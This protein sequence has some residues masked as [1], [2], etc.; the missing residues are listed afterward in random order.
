ML[1]SCHSKQQILQN[2]TFCRLSS[3]NITTHSTGILPSPGVKTFYF[4]VQ[5]HV[6]V[7]KRC[8]ALPG[9]IHRDLFRP[10][11]GMK[12]PS[13]NIVHTSPGNCSPA[14]NSSASVITPSYSK[15]TKCHT[16]SYINS[17]PFG[18]KLEHYQSIS[19]FVYRYIG[20]F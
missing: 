16:S 14:S 17:T 8:F 11:M 20:P 1:Q 15:S 4:K 13:D 2:S 5:T 7:I 9:S 10:T 12:H 18:Q 3:L 19:Y 6:Y